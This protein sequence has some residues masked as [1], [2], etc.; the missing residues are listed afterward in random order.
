MDTLYPALYGVGALG[1]LPLA[2]TV[3][4]AIVRSHRE[5]RRQ[6][7]LDRFDRRIH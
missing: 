6:A 7:M 5:R 1:L 2:A 3:I 4:G